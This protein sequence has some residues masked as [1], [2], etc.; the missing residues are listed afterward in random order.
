[1]L[2]KFYADIFLLTYNKTQV[3]LGYTKVVTVCTT[4]SE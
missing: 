3:K 2:S 1:M 4:V